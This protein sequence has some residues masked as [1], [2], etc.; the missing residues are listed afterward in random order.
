MARLLN[1]KCRKDASTRSF[2]VMESSHSLL[3]GSWSLSTRD[4]GPGVRNYK[5]KSGFY[6]RLKK[7]LNMN[8][9]FVSCASG[10]M[11]PRRWAE[12]SASAGRKRGMAASSQK[13]SVLVVP[14]TSF[15]FDV[16][17]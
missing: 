6:R 17:S 7:H 2:K 15:G 1:A 11:S 16:V 3:A 5:N 8:F 9:P 10:V 13:S 4:P 14:W 12:S